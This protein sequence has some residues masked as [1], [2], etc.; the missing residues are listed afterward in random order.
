MKQGICY[1]VGA[2][3]DYGLDFTP[4]A[5]DYVIAADAGFVVLEKKHVRID[6]AIGDFDTLGVP[7][8]HSN[9]IVLN[10]EKDT[11][12]MQSA[13]YEGIK[14]G[15]GS[16]HIY[17]GTGGRVEH[18]IANVQLLA[19]L[20]RDG[21]RGFLYGKNYII[22]ALTDAAVEFP[23]SA[24]GF[25]SVF[26][27]SDRSEGVYLRGLK[28]ELENAVLTNTNPLG[29]SNE[30]IGKKSSISVADGTLVLVYGNGIREGA[31]NGI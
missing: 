12:D 14:R 9:V 18:T 19:E 21:R 2:G 13:V 23:D 16:F 5:E 28:Y 30:F 27:H 31:Q 15:Y 7:P 22:T 8:C 6:M 24:S 17:G 26:S 3:G 10:R 1:V 29:V 4:G 25:V 11:T 20:A